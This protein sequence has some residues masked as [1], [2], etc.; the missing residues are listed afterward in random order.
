MRGYRQTVVREQPLSL[1]T[2]IEGIGYE[3]ISHS[4]LIAMGT[5]RV[6]PFQAV[7]LSTAVQL[8]VKIDALGIRL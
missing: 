1:P 3:S 7:S 2:I 4:I 5:T 8:L 6:P